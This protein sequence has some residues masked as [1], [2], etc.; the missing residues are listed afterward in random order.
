MA[1]NDMMELGSTG[2]HRNGGV[3]YEEF[4]NELRGDRWLKVVREMSEQD[5]IV[6]AFLLAIEMML[7]Q[8]DW[9]I[10][11]GAEKDT[12]AA[13][14][15]TFVEECMM[16]MSLSWE[17]TLS[18]ILTML[19]YG[20]SY[21]ETVYKKRNGQASDDSSKYTDGKIGWRKWAIRA[22]DSR[23][24]WQ[25]DD[26]GGIQGFWQSVD[27][28]TPVLIPIEKSLLFRTSARK[29]NPEGRSVLRG[30]YRPWYFKKHLENIEGIGV[31][32]DLAGLPVAKVPI[33]ILLPSASDGQKAL[34]AQIQNIVTGI[35]RDEQEGVIWPLAYDDKGNET[36]K[37][38]LLS[39]PGA[40]QFDIGAI[41]SRYNAQIAM[42]A[43]ADFITLGHEKVG[44][45]GLSATKSSL[46]K[47]ALKG[48]LD[49]IADVINTHA[50]PR[51]L[52]VNGMST[53]NPP[54]LKFSSVGDVDLADLI[55][56]IQTA[57]GA[58]MQLFPSIELENS[59]RG[60]L[61]LPLLSEDEVARRQ[62]QDE[63]ATLPQVAQP[64]PTEPTLDNVA[65]AIVR[66]S[67]RALG[68]YAE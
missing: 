2:L 34:Y 58:G 11:P 9:E 41:I 22:Q 37:L 30:A 16:D 59:L 13:E 44:S 20:Y 42:S 8:V 56:F 31:E 63:Q 14:I 23:W 45:Y 50:I 55:Q 19:P 48:W 15:A 65:A 21:L 52:R 46:F 32:R 4:L 28:S 29:G 39:A 5:P 60:M 67:E 51:L 25:F 24:Q 6:T 53:D 26:K 36:Y 43:L 1:P 64:M 10:Q 27:G 66:A 17:D 35:R 57:S 33:E 18:E 47:T 12:A 49:S 54:T 38:E 3:V 7:R 62:A 40:R 68:I 61:R